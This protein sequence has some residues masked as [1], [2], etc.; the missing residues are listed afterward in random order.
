MA[1]NARQNKN[2]TGALGQPT[3]QA[4]VYGVW[5]TGIGIGVVLVV[6]LAG[7]VGNSYL[8]TARQS[9]DANSIR[10][11]DQ[12][13]PGAQITRGVSYNDPIAI[14]TTNG[15]VDEVEAWKT[16]GADGTKHLQDA[17]AR[18]GVYYAQICIGCHAGPIN[19]VSNGPWIGNLYQTKYLYNGQPLNDANLVYFLL[20]GHGNMPAGIPLAQQAVDTMLYLKQQ[21]T[22]R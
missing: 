17:T 9:E 21:T 13:Y 22:P 19:S 10:A 20:R 6:I 11:K 14:N 8:P 4:T 16:G 2:A 5:F 7:L 12:K 1:Y 15:T 18:G 3:A